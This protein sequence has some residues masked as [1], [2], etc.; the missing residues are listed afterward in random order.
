MTAKIDIGGLRFGRWVVVAHAGLRLWFCH[1]DCGTEKAV[2]AGSLRSGRSS[3]CIKCHPGRSNRRTHG[4]KRTRLYNIWSGMKARCENP[5]EAA[6][7]RY[8]GRGIM[9]CT[10]WRSDFV[11]FRAWALENGYSPELT[12]DRRENDLG[13][14]PSNCR[15]RTY[16]E[17]NRNRRNH[18]PVMF[19]GK[20]V[21]ISELADR[22]GLPADILKNRI[23]RYG[24]SIE[25]A[26]STPVQPR[27]GAR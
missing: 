22:Y 20:S 18:K 15:W 12:I 3:G 2:D 19:N 24:W 7:P 4:E 8:G 23:T 17:Q 11:A 5:N 1:C 14:S 6:Y 25:K 21:L 13:Y 27:G 9:V 26:I 10:E 16:T